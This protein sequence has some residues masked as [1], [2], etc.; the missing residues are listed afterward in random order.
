MEAVRAVM[1]AAGGLGPLLGVGVLAAALAAV[2]A[3]HAYHRG[4]ASTHCVERLGPVA[5]AMTWPTTVALATTWVATVALA[6]VLAYQQGT[7]SAH[8]HAV[9]PVVQPA[10]PVPAA[11]QPEEQ[12]L[13][14]VQPEEPMP[15]AVE[16]PEYWTISTAGDGKRV[17][18]LDPGCFRLRNKT[19][20][21][22]TVQ[23]YIAESC[24]INCK[25][26]A[27]SGKAF[28]CEDYVA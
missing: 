28:P 8:A 20:E 2:L 11:V 5:P 19:V 21:K 6:T 3:Y 22:I 26:R 16:E 7:A 9:E 4:A 12:V 18:H 24:C 23:E 13:A 17:L 14:A 25:D 10:E 27:P 1:A 15:A